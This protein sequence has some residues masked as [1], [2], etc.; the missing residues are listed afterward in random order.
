[1]T[2]FPPTPCLSIRGGHTIE[3]TAQN[4]KKKKGRGM[5]LTGQR[6]VAADEPYI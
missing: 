1:M 6:F 2:P 3:G 5:R 4:Q